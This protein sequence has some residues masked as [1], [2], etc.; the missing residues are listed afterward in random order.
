MS[1]GVTHF[2]WQIGP[3]MGLNHSHEMVLGLGI[4]IARPCSVYI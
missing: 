3:M 2:A 1:F 4:G